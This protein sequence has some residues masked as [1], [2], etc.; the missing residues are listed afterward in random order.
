MIAIIDGSG[1]N[2]ASIQFALTRL[3]KKFELT[4]DPQFIKESAHVIIPGVSTAQRAMNELK[5]RNLVQTIQSLKQPVLGICSG[6]QILFDWCEEGQVE[7]LGIFTD[8]VN[9]ISPQENLTLPHMG[10]N[11]LKLEKPNCALLCDIAEK[12]YVYFVH[13]FAAK[14]GEYTVASS[15][16]GS[17][18]SAVVAKDNFFGTQFHPER[19][20]KVGTRILYNFL[21]YGNSYADYSSH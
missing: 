13:S 4:S 15:E 1:T 6:M 16:Y 17:S 3:G 8:K 19:S 11:T 10:W 5:K 18:F 21:Q 2:I 14:I 20:G 9:K 7:G 12:D